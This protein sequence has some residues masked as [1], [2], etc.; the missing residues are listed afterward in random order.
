MC[1][2]QTYEGLLGTCGGGG[3]NKTPE[4]TNTKQEQ[5]PTGESLGT[6]RRRDPAFALR[7]PELMSESGVKNGIVTCL[8]GR[9][10]RRQRERPSR[11]P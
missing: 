10:L 9:V 7:M 11:P 4:I 3:G 5:L 2:A 6:L 8:E 1:I